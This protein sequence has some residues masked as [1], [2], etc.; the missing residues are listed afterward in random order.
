MIRSTLFFSAWLLGACHVV[1]APET[2]E[3]LVVFGFQHFDDEDEDA[4][5]E[6]EVNLGPLVLENIDQM[7]EGYAVNQLTAEDLQT[8]GIEDADVTE[9]IGAMG[10]IDYRHDLDAVLDPMIHDHKDEIF[11]DNWLSYE[12]LEQT[13]RACFIAH[14]CD[15]YAFT[16]DQTADA[17]LL[18]EATQ[19]IDHSLRW[20]SREDGTL[21][22]VWRT[23]AP[24]PIA[25]TSNLMAVHQ[26]YAL[27]T[28]VPNGDVARRIE[29]FW[30]DAE[31]I[32]LD[33]PEYTA[34]NNAVKQMGVQADRIDDFLDEQASP[35]E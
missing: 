34:V 25:F 33:V 8:A 16:V 29:A 32:G 7:S 5:R 12:I 22:L 3:E 17:A 1:R 4:L 19:T 21:F 31:F 13:D 30:V 10:A 27:V 23:L 18:G 9:I 11:P 2:I 26:Q 28:I 20:V 15:R 14:T 6:M 24:E 35:A